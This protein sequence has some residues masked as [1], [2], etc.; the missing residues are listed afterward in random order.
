MFYHG[1]IGPDNE[2]SKARRWL[3]KEVADAP[4]LHA[5]TGRFT[6]ES[7]DSPASLVEKLK[8]NYAFFSRMTYDEIVNL[9]RWCERKHFPAGA[10]IFEKGNPS[11]DFFLIVFGQV[12]VRVGEKELA[13]LGPGECFGEMG[14]LEEAPRNATVTA[15]QDTLV[16][17][18]E[19]GL[20]TGENPTLGYKILAQVAKQLSERLRKMND[21]LKK[22]RS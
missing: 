18:I 15:T 10:V 5:V 6:R 14:V 17:C 9:M 22:I 4:H 19:G 21:L 8:R 1:R 11:E 16:L 12:A 20:L 3:R 7:D 2:P 13:R